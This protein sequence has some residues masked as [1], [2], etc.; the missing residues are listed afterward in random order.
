ME[1]KDYRHLPIS[2]ITKWIIEEKLN[3]Q[4]LGR[5]LREH[6][7]DVRDNLRNEK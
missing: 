1:S 6:Y 5:R 2:V 4:Q 7:W 3:E